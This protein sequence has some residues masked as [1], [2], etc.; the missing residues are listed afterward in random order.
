MMM[1]FHSSDREDIAELQWR[2][3]SPVSVLCLV[4]LA[5]ALSQ[6][7]LGQRYAKLLFAILLYL[8]YSQLLGTAKRWVANGTWPAL[9]GTWT[10]HALCLVLALVLF[11]ASQLGTVRAWRWRPGG[12]RPLTAPSAAESR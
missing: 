9:P 2:I 4:L 5:I 8:G 7:H 11:G 1:L 6:I 3:A 10:I 12:R